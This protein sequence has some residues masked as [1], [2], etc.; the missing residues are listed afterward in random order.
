MKNAALI[1]IILLSITA[2]ASPDTSAYYAASRLD[3]YTNEEAGEIMVFV[4]SGKKNDRITTDLVFE[5]QNLNKGY[6]VFSSGISTIPFPTKLLK[7]GKNEITV[8]FYENEK[9]V[10]SRKVWVEIRQPKDNAVKIDHATGGLVISGMPMLPVG[11]SSSF[12]VDLKMADYSAA[13]GFNLVSPKH[14]ID[15]KTLKARKAY[16]DR[17]ASLGIRVNYDLSSLMEPGPEMKPVSERLEMI[18]REVELFRDH[19]ALLAWYL[20]EG[21]DTKNLAPDSLREAYHFIREL[22]PYHPVCILL[23]SPRN[24]A[25]YQDVMDI[26]M[27]APNPFPQGTLMEIKDYARVINNA[28]WLQKPSWIIPQTYGGSGYYHREPT[29]QELRAMTYMALISGTTGVQYAN[30][31]PDH[32]PKSTALWDECGMLA[33]EIAELTPDILS[34]HPAPEL[35]PDNT[36]IHSKAWNR[37]GLV[38]IVVVNSKNEPGNFRI[39]MKDIDLT[40]QADVMFE[41][42]KVEIKDGLVE[43]IIEG[44]GTRIYRFDARLKP[45]WVKELQR[46][47][48][49]IDPGFEDLSNVGVP[50]G[51]YVIKGNDPGGTYFIDSR[52]HYLGEHSL[53]LNNPSHLPGDRLL[54]LCPGISEKKSYSISIMAKTGASPNLPSAKN[55]NQVGFNLG[56]GN[57]MQAFTLTDTWQKY[58]ISNIMVNGNETGSPLL[59]MAGKGTAWF[60]NLLVYPDMELVESKGEGGKVIIEIKCVHPDA[61]IF[62]T[63]DGSEPTSLSEEYKIP[64]EVDRSVVIKASAFLQGSRVGYIE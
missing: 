41:N 43:D 64:L 58:E 35:I 53:K 26:V 62:H 19:P 46:G 5:Y 17:F 61:K 39:R 44:Y 10:D 48:L 14:E 11:F 33:L 52:R 56:L 22:D 54:F 7:E 21:P 42:R 28:L 29:P 34:P 13:R 50:A 18:R 16:M 31:G 25:Q 2:N 4:P 30:H 59:Q 60:D 1:F 40:I 36:W 32:S 12:P 55:E 8:S 45:D 51:C 47:N 3:Y 37:A 15:K 57:A 27:T 24:A 49:T 38:T 20:A 63:S 9:W 23:N 6:P